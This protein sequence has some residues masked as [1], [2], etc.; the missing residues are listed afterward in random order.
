MTNAVDAVGQPGGG[1]FQ[2]HCHLLTRLL[3]RILPADLPRADAPWCSHQHPCFQRLMA[4]QH[5]PKSTV[6]RRRPSPQ[7]HSPTPERRR[8]C[9]TCCCTCT[10]TGGQ[11]AGRNRRNMRNRCCRRGRHGDGAPAACCRAGRSCAV[12]CRRP[13]SAGG[14]D[15]ATAAAPHATAGSP[16]LRTVP[17]QVP[18]SG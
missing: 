13:E 8:R 4:A 3:A 18:V 5:L 7:A 9:S 10:W 16:L 1:Q 12:R 15:P 11:E 2:I 6:N 14:R 17:V